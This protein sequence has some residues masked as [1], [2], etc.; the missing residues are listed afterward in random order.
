[1][2]LKVDLNLEFILNLQNLK[3][4]CIVYMYK[5]ESILIYH[6]V[7]RVLTIFQNNF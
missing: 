2:Y 7:T 3:D 5:N 4:I 6:I 1:M